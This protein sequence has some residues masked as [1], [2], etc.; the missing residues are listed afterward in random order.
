MFCP[1]GCILFSGTQIP[2]S[3]EGQGFSVCLGIIFN[4]WRAALDPTS[5]VDAAKR[6][7]KLLEKV[8]GE[9]AVLQQD[10]LLYN[11]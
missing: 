6:Q 4:A 11:L 8:L 2:T 10:L 7:P 1:Q 9:A 3:L 5:T